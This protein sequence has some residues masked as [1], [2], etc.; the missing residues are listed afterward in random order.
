LHCKFVL[1]ERPEGG[2]PVPIKSAAAPEPAIPKSHGAP[3]APSIG[4]KVAAAGGARAV[5]A[6]QPPAATKS[7]P[8]GISAEEFKNDPRIQSA[9]KLFAGRIVDVRAQ[10][11]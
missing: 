3:G 5:S 6:N 11:N 9:L 1:A 2:E 8:V 4:P 10:A 7:A